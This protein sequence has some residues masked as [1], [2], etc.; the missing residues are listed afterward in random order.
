MASDKHRDSQDGNRGEG[1]DRD[2]ETEIMTKIGAGDGTKTEA[3]NLTGSA[4]GIAIGTRNEDR[5]GVSSAAKLGTMRTSVAGSRHHR[6]RVILTMADH[7]HQGEDTKEYIQLKRSKKEEKEAMRKEKAL[8]KQREEEERMEREQ[9]MARKIEKEKRAEI[10]QMKLAKYVDVQLSLK[11][12][13]LRDEI[14]QELRKVIRGKSKEKAPVPSDDDSDNGSD[15][16]TEDLSARTGQLTL[17][18]ERKRGGDPGF[19][20]NPPMV[21]PLKRTPACQTVIVPTKLTPR[22]KSRTPKTKLKS[23]MKVRVRGRPTS[24]KK[25]PAECREDGKYRYLE[26]LRRDLIDMD[27]KT[28]ESMCKDVGIDYSGK[29][30]AIFDIAN[31]KA[32]EAYGSGHESGAAEKESVEDEADNRSANEGKNEDA[33][34]NQE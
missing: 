25:I 9:R 12:G 14:R 20:D 2:R 21:G 27:A 28:M 19:E 32:N 29:M 31:Q 3:G 10:K 13:E 22:L 1:R 15:D 11:I 34:L 4:T 26:T 5:L 8:A 7:S 30:H 33:T 17:N 16:D 6:R 24:S 18:E 23:S